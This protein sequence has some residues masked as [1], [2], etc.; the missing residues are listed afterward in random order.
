MEE[1]LRLKYS[2]CSHKKA[3]K[4]LICREKNIKIGRF[5]ENLKPKQT[6]KSWLAKLREYPLDVLC[7]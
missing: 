2:Y 1:N 7:L 6:E 4:I 5:T 3:C